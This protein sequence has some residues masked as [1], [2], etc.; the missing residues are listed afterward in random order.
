MFIG[1]WAKTQEI[2][3]Q[4]FI[5]TKVDILLSVNDDRWCCFVQYASNFK[6]LSLKKFSMKLD[7]FNIPYLG[8][9]LEGDAKETECHEAHAMALG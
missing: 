5:A 1:E 3:D 9:M 4:L 2:G 7:E 6:N 8:A